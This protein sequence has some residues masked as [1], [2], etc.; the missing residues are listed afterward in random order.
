MIQKIMNYVIFF[1]TITFIL[2]YSS[3]SLDINNEDLEDRIYSIF[4]KEELETIKLVSVK[5][6]FYY[7]VILSDKINLIKL[8][9]EIRKLENS[10]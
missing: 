7:S 3:L 2:L 1:N 8:D 10:N 5:N 6:S 4:K 9:R